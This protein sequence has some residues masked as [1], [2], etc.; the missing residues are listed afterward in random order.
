M[1]N[2]E[3]KILDCTLRDGGYYNS[4]DFNRDL[5]K[6]Y[7]DSLSSSRIDCIELGF[8]HLPSDN[9]RGPFSYTSD[10]FLLGLDLPENILYAVMIN[11]SEYLETKNPR[12]VIKDYFSLSKDSPVSLVRIAINFEE[13]DKS[14][15]LA[16]DLKAQ[17]YMVALNLM[18]SHSRKRK[19]YMEVAKEIS[20]WGT[21]DV[22]YFA[23]SFGVME[24]TDVSDLYSCLKDSWEKDLGFHPHNNKGFALINSLAALDS[25]VKWIDATISG[26]GRGAGNAFTEAVLMEL[27]SRNQHSGNPFN[28][29]DILEEFEEL[30]KEFKWG[31]NP[32]YHFASS[33]LIHP[34]YVQTLISDKRYSSKEVG[35]ALLSLSKIKSS[36]FS[37]VKL[38]KAI[39]ENT[40][41][42]KFLGKWD[43]F[44]WLK[45]EDVLLIG[46]GPST[47]KYSQDI[48]KFRKSLKMKTFLL[49][50]S[51]TFDHK[52]V[53][54][55][56]I[57]NVDRVIIDS[58]SYSEVDSKLILPYE[59]FKDVIGK[60]QKK[61]ILDYGLVLEENKFDIEPTY[62]KI[63]SPVVTAYALAV[64]YRA[65]VKR[66][67]FSGLDGYSGSDIRNNEMEYIFKKFNNLKNSPEIISITPTL[68]TGIKKSSVFSPEF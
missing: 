21:V 44:D 68:Y 12:K 27:Y 51:E 17:G 48:N 37:P 23:D 62:C 28:L 1:N 33:N 31:P 34:T 4:W 3:I 43:P 25:G 36:S 5:V 14:N 63:F 24:P 65:G 29:L 46:P 53:S 19:D 35:N 47:Q 9:F 60:I 66:I 49:N 42:Q 67:F 58:F 41:K 8:R 7:L 64:L 20:K 2:K 18:Q 61:N 26:M 52:D 38:K 45:D 22:L 59:R 57:S 50:N 10:K 54:A 15:I 39:Y 13:Y 55:I 30:R 11:A 32:L 56:F 40:T 16:E 6:R